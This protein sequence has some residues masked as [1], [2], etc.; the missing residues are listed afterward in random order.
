MEYG[1]ILF[2]FTILGLLLFRILLHI[3]RN[4]INQASPESINT[5][6]TRSKTSDEPN[7]TGNLEAVKLIHQ[8]NLEKT[9]LTVAT[10]ISGLVLLAALY[11]ILAGKTSSESEKWAFGAV[12]TIIGYWLKV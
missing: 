2:I 8:Q 1:L 6:R 3:Q 12:G 5:L 4:R 7:A 11:I 10:I 9:R